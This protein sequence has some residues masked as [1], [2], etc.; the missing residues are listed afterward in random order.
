LR[1]R[2]RGYYSSSTGASKPSSL[3]SLSV[4]CLLQPCLSMRIFPCSIT[5]HL[6]SRLR[7]S[8]HVSSFALTGGGN[9]SHFRHTAAAVGRFILLGM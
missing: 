9:E 2:L 7:S 4:P 6:H 5:L 8:P 3:A 1:R